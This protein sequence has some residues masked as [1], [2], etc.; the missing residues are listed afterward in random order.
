[1]LPYRDK[2]RRFILRSKVS[3]IGAESTLYIIIC[4]FKYFYRAKGAAA[5]LHIKTVAYTQS[6]RIALSLHLSRHVLHRLI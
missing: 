1:M 5:L 3:L 6:A 4:S 2:Y